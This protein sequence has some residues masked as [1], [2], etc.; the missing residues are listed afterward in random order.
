[1]VAVVLQTLEPGMPLFIKDHDFAVEDGLVLELLRGSGDRP[2][3]LRE[4]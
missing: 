2:I 3:A 4:G 1:M